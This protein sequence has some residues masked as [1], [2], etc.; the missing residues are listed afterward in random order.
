MRILVVE[1]EDRIIDFLKSAL[2]AEHFMVDTAKD[3]KKGSFLAR[4]NGYDLVILDNKLPKKDGQQVC[5]EVRQAGKTVPILMLSVISDAD[6]KADLLNAGADDYLTKP[7]ALPELLARI[8]ALLRR[9]AQI[10]DEVLQINDLSL[11]IK[12]HMVKRGNKEVYLTRKLFSLL[13]YMMRNRGTVLSRAMIMEHVW[14]MN[15]DPFSN[16]IETHM[17]TLR[18]KIDHASRKKLIH[19]MPCRGYMIGER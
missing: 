3:G 17:L 6:K 1:D 8:R 12:K 16:T 2:E 4:T 14:D 13:E 11:D 15:I 10:E 7:F 18:K 9:P 19:T 5:E